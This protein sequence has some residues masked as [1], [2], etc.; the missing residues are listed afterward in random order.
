M[1]RPYTTFYLLA[2]ARFTLSVTI[3]EK[4]AIKMCMT[5]TLTFRMVKVKYKYANGKAL[6]NFQFVGNSNA[7]TICHHLREIGNRNVNDLDLNL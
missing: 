4:L 5:L 1:E 7:C 3:C 2:I 6:C